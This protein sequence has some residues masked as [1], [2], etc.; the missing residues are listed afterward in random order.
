VNLNLVAVAANTCAI[1]GPIM[2]APITRDGFHVI[3]LRSTIFRALIVMHGNLPQHL[4][5]EMET[6]FGSRHRDLRAGLLRL[7]IALIAAENR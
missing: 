4:T 1:P 2:P 3:S 6:R 5:G 7:A